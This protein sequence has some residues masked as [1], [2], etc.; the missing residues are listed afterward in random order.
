MIFN[1]P[2]S[3]LSLPGFFYVFPVAITARSV[4]MFFKNETFFYLQ[5][6]ITGEVRLMNKVLYFITLPC[7]LVY[8]RIE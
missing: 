3:A 4:M 6:Q 2:R 5:V 8:G 7:C 1:K